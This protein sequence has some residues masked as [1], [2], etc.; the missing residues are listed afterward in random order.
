MRPWSLGNTHDEDDRR[1][2]KGTKRTRERK[3]MKNGDESAGEESL[4]KGL[5]G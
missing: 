3:L 5:V 2:E 4:Q 1:H